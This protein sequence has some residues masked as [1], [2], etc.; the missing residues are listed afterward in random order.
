MPRLPCQP[1][2]VAA[3][4]QH[5]AYAGY[6]VAGDLAARAGDADDNVGRLRRCGHYRRPVRR[7]DRLV[8]PRLRRALPDPC[9]LF[10]CSQGRA[11]AD[12]GAGFGAGAWPAILTAMSMGVFPVVVN[13]AAGLAT[14]EPELKEFMTVLKAKQLDILWNIGLPRSLPYLFASLKVA[15]TLAFVGAV[16]SETVAS[17]K[18]IG[19]MMMIASSNYDVPLTF[20]G[21]FVLAAMGIVFY[22]VFSLLEL[23]FTGWAHRGSG[24]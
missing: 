11:S 12:P 9:R 21:L 1:A 24:H 13:V 8:A 7:F 14:I 20:A 6:E 17:N 19:N 2:R 22:V 10:D 18:G 3:A 15:I 4:E 5:R 16:I 23:R